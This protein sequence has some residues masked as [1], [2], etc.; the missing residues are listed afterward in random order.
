MPADT[1]LMGFAAQLQSTAKL[2]GRNAGCFIQLNAEKMQ[3]ESEKLC[4]FNFHQWR[5]QR[6]KPEDP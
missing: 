5:Q 4:S 2:Q 6:C 3:P 1:K